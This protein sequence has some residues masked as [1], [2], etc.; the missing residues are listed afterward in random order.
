MISTFAALPALF[1]VF[2]HVYSYF[3]CTFVHFF[4]ET[5]VICISQHSLIGQCLSLNDYFEV[6][7]KTELFR[8]CAV[9]ISMNR[10]AEFAFEHSTIL[11]II[12]HKELIFM[13]YPMNHPNNAQYRLYV[14]VT[15]S[16]LFIWTFSKVQLF[17]SYVI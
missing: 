14:Y 17:I 13:K 6:Q 15:L 2:Y 10:N 8:R 1:A 5:N 4:Q 12:E 11:F 3:L 9:F 16:V 7:Y